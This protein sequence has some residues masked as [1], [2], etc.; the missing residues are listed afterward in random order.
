MSS[1]SI[2]YRTARCYVEAGVEGCADDPYV[3]Y[4]VHTVRKVGVYNKWH[5]TFKG[6]ADPQTRV[7]RSWNS[8]GREE[9]LSIISAAARAIESC[10]ALEETEAEREDL[11]SA[12]L[13]AIEALKEVRQITGS[14]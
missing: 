4:S 6:F 5:H 9:R 1:T 8:P 10:D 14:I 2:V 11:E 3:R 12:A 7:A 13:N